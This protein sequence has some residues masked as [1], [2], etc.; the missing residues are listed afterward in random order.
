MGNDPGEAWGVSLANQ[1]KQPNQSNPNPKAWQWGRFLSHDLKCCEGLVKSCQVMVIGPIIDWKIHC[2]W[3]SLRYLTGCSMT[4][5]DCWR[6]WL[7]WQTSARFIISVLLISQMPR[8]FWFRPTSSVAAEKCGLPCDS[9]ET[10]VLRWHAAMSSQVSRTIS[11]TFRNLIDTK[12]QLVSNVSFR[13]Y[14]ILNS[15]DQHQH[16]ING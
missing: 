14:I 11:K 5:L 7:I 16:Y 9:H 12:V 4:V 2:F 10:P 1:G 15:V 6:Y 3:E 8:R 13:K